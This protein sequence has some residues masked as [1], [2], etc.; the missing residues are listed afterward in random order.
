MMS[1]TLLPG[2]MLRGQDAASKELKLIEKIFFFL[3]P[4]A[5]LR[6]PFEVPYSDILGFGLFIVYLLKGKPVI[7]KSLL[8]SLL[9]F[10]LGATLA[11]FRNQDLATSLKGMIHHT[12]IILILPVVIFGAIDSEEKILTAL[13]CYI[14]GTLVDALLV[15]GYVIFNMDSRFVGS[16]FLTSRVT[17]VYGPNVTARLFCIAALAALYF[18]LNSDRA[19]QRIFYLGAFLLF[20]F[21]VMTTVSVSGVFLLVVGSVVVL[22]RF[23]AG[24]YRKNI[25]RVLMGI[26]CMMIIALILYVCIPSIHVQIDKMAF[27]I[28]TNREEGN[29]L[30]GRTDFFPLFFQNFHEYLIAGI[31]YSCSYYV[32]GK[33]IHFPFFA[34]LVEVGIF[35]FASLMILYCYPIFC[36]FKRE[37]YRRWDISAII[38]MV[39]LCGDMIQ[40]NP[41]Y[42]FSWFAIFCACLCFRGADVGPKAPPLVGAEESARCSMVPHEME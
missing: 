16:V 41:N 10:W 15:V 30:H 12:I 38:A 25:A 3:L 32:Y 22:M 33:T 13:K 24:R 35:G 19:K 11:L 8:F 40:P 2:E 26:F 17:I 1:K 28:L 9:L 31:G 20:V 6:G 27:R 39:I 18:V 5:F 23:T 37:R 7:R 36:I 34:A 14:F 21:C 4:I 42:R 29:L